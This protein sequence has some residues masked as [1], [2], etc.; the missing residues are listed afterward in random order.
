MDAGLCEE[1]CSR[2]CRKREVGDGRAGQAGRESA[3]KREQFAFVEEGDVV[4]EAARAGDQA[5]WG[6]QC[7]GEGG[8]DEHECVCSEGIGAWE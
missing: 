7:E 2:S 8:W 6:I 5:A 1:R 3:E 4:W